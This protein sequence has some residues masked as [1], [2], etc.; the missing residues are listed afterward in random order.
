MP[1]LSLGSRG[2]RVFQH[3][4]HACCSLAIDVSLSCNWILVISGV[5]VVNWR[6]AIGGAYSTW[7]HPSICSTRSRRP[8]RSWQSARSRRLTGLLRALQRDLVDHMKT[9]QLPLH[10]AF[11]VCFNMK[12]TR[13]HLLGPRGSGDYIW[14]QRSWGV[15]GIWV[16]NGPAVV[17]WILATD[18]VVVINGVLLINGRVAYW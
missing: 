4:T 1:W 12:L 13:L 15:K 2:R 8:T 14:N 16:S 17:N 10:R 6:V 18:G 5:G 9:L 11:C 7:S 3:E